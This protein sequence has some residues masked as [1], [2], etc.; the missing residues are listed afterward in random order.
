MHRASRYA[1]LAA[2]LAALSIPGVAPASDTMIN[3][4]G[5]VDYTRKPTF[6]IGDWVRYR[7]TGGN[8]MGEKVDYVMTVLIGGEQR[9][10]GEDCFW[11]ETWTVPNDG[12]AVYGVSTL[13]SYAIFSDSAAIP[14]MKLYMR[15]TVND[16]DEQG[17]PIETLLKRPPL[18]LKSRTAPSERLA[19]DYDTLGTDTVMV[20]KGSFK[21]TKVRMRDGIAVTSEKPDSTMRTEL[22]E[23][24]T[25]YLDD[26]IPIT[27]IVREAI[28]QT[29][30]KQMWAV[31]RS[32]E[33]T[34]M[35]LSGQSTGDA[36]LED[37][38][39]GMQPRVTPARYHRS[40]KEQES[41]S[42]SAKPKAKPKAMSGSGS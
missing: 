17:N 40:I 36:R 8:T 35:Q 18:S 23:T 27:R 19:W 7:V 25:I 20:P 3:G 15:K 32:R 11:V 34:G 41:P 31:G 28:D 37:Y 13:M 21:C 16:V 6:K 26:R 33:G 10:W 30:S 12:G 22:M 39:H 24:R 38:G 29:T 14:R 5:L 2:V 1:L 9:F 42:A 4:I